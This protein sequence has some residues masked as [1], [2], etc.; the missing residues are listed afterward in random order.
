MEWWKN[1]REFQKQ[2][3]EESSFLQ[4][5]IY[6]PRPKQIWW[7]VIK[8]GGQTESYPFLYFPKYSC[9]FSENNQTFL[10]KMY[11]FLVETD[12]RRWGIPLAKYNY[13]KARNQ[14]VQSIVKINNNK[15][16]HSIFFPLKIQNPKDPFHL[17]PIKH[18]AKQNNL[19]SQE[20][21]SRFISYRLPTPSYM[22]FFPQVV[23]ISP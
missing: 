4:L 5:P 15:K 8:R 20:T 18:E 19:A 2:R 12:C 22:N 16:I 13:Y 21:I 11:Y 10:F 17:V 14:K 23:A 7:R 9:L 1:I 6:N 3:V